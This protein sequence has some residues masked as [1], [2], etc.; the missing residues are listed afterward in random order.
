M[1]LGFV[2]PMMWDPREGKW[3][4]LKE[5][6]NKWIVMKLSNSGMK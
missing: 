4:S 1:Q 3:T 5:F 6:W 2:K